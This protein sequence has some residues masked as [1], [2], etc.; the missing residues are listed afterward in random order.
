MPPDHEVLTVEYKVNFVAPARVCKLI[1]VGQ[2]IKPGRRV[3]VCRGDVFMV[4]EEG[5]RKSARP[6]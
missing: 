6:C 2:V 1:S 5:G 3:T 4:G